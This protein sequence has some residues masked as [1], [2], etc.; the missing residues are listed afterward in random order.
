M[1]VIHELLVVWCFQQTSLANV[2]CLY[3]NKRLQVTY[4][5]TSDM[6]WVLCFLTHITM[7]ITVIHVFEVT[8]HATEAQGMGYEVQWCLKHDVNHVV[9]F[10]D[11][12]TRHM[13]L[14]QCNCHTL[15]TCIK[16]RIRPPTYVHAMY[17]R[18]SIVTNHCNW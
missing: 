13:W 5:G 2:T 7:Q 17:K 16:L 14:V 10:T 11:P 1:C 4:C 8:V 15:I 12:L 6:S 3:R 18:K 9:C